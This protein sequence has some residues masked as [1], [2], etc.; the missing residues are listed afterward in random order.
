MSTNP[1]PP[2]AATAFMKTSW[3]TMQTHDIKQNLLEAIVEDPEIGHSTN[4]T[5]NIRAGS[6]GSG[7]EIELVG[8]VDSE[9]DKARTEEV[10]RVNTAGEASI[11]NNL[12]LG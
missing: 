6:Q 11:T 10:V 2:A 7:P 8:K 5:V 3:R 4:I 12:I 9:K 1:T